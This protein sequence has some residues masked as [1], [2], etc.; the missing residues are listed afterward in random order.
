MNS[1]TPAFSIPEILSIIG[2]VQCVY[3]V[4][5]MLFQSGAGGS[6]G[7]AALPVLY[8]FTLGLA[9][10]SD[11]SESVLSA[12]T[13][14]AY[15]L[16]WGAWFA[17]PPLSVLLVIQIAQG[18]KVPSFKDY[19]VLLLL[20]LSFMLSMLAVDVSKSCEG[21]EP[22]ED[23]RALLDVTGLMAGAISLLVIFS[24]KGL[25]S[26]TLKQKNGK[27][28]YWLIFSLIA[29]N[30]LFLAAMMARLMHY[31][32]YEDAALAR[33]VLGLAFV[34]L[35]ST[36]FL[37]LYPQP[38]RAV[39]TVG[40]RGEEVLSEDELVLARKIEDL[41]K[42]DKVYH[43]PAYSRTDLARECDAPET[44]I[45]KVINVYF[46]KSFPQIMN[47]CRIEDARRLLL[48]TEAS[49]K[50]VAEEVG[51]NSLPSFNRVF[52]DITGE[53]PSQYRKSIKK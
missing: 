23:I 14:Y 39:S 8:F 40:T 49:I 26:L 17:G 44:V 48:E 24:K 47:E 41:L 16:Q 1:V 9:F 20:P 36:G 38:T 15:Y 22:C 12:L 25:F 53:A 2:L 10:F 29:V 31:V 18:N 5:H 21:F 11:F 32:S 35:V 37:R 34:Y 42:L 4:V 13:P 30:L 46:Q 51:F 3:L 7:R 33:T 6:L 27:E 50:T 19:W 45:S 28:R 52:K 43:E